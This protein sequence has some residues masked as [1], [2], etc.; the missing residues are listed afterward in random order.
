MKSSDFVYFVFDF[1]VN[2]DNCTHFA[3]KFSDVQHVV[4]SE[5]SYS[6]WLH[7]RDLVTY[8]TRPVFP[9]QQIWQH[10]IVI[11]EILTFES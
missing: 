5:I 1:I 9:Q 8:V 3:N 2:K 4:T 10:C 7:I 6:L 11:V